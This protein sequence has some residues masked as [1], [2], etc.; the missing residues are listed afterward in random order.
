M[1]GI[2]L[3][4][5]EVFQMI[6]DEPN[7]LTGTWG[8]LALVR[9]LRLLNCRLYYT[10]SLQTKPM[11]KAKLWRNQPITKRHG[12]G[13]LLR[14]TM[15]REPTS[16]HYCAQHSAGGFLRPKTE[17][18]SSRKMHLHRAYLLPIPA[19]AQGRCLSPTTNDPGAFGFGRRLNVLRVEAC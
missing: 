3:R 6:K 1:N 14:L 18:P 9:V 4:Q 15:P 13:R 12:L 10:E 7:P 19:L 8:I 2:K 16:L 11:T 17:S 5:H